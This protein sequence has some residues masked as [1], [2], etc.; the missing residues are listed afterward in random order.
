MSI[1]LIDWWRVRCSLS[2]YIRPARDGPQEHWWL[3]AERG[4]MNKEN[5]TWREI[6]ACSDAAKIASEEVRA[7][8]LQEATSA[9]ESGQVERS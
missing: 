1:P 9:K 5:M 2:L 7:R 3:E 6:V 8:L 4:M